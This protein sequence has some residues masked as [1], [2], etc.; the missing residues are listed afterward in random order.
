MNI[1]VKCAASLLP[2][3]L[4]GHDV[5]EIVGSDKS[6]IIEV[7]FVEYVIPFIVTHV[8]S[9]FLTNLFQLSCGDFSLN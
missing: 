6:I 2:I 8:L 4:V 3:N 7:S 9:E 5:I 1:D